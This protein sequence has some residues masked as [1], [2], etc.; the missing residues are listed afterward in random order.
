M[1]QLELEQYAYVAL[2]PGRLE[3]RLLELEP[4]A[5]LLDD[6]VHANIKHASLLELP[7]PAYET[8]VLTVHS[9]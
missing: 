4:T 8:C 3:I 1:R 9:G 6:F 2:V 7:T 5:S